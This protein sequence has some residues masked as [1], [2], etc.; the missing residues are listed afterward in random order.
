MGKGWNKIARPYLNGNGYNAEK[1]VEYAYKWTMDS[2]DPNYQPKRN[3]D[4]NYYKKG[5]NLTS[6]ND[7]TNFVS[8]VL[9][10]GGGIDQV[11]K[12]VWG[13]DY[14]SMENW[15]YNEGWFFSQK[16][17]YSWGGAD[18]LYKHLKS[19]SEGVRRVYNTSDLQIGDLVQVDMEDDGKFHIDHSVVV[20]KIEDGEIFVTYHTTDQVDEPLSTFYKND[21]YTMYAWAIN[22]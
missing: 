22:H 20:T 18:S 3:P 14:K 19:H 11:H 12:D 9:H 2:D 17:S 21:E 10:E 5:D 16:P 6:W 15:Y 1:A 7:C 4:Y 13:L 8:Q